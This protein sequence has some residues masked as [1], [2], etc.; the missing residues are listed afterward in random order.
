LFN[1]ALA[2]LAMSLMAS[3]V[4]PQQQECLALNV[5]HESRDQSRIGMVAVAQVVLNRVRDPRFPNTIC[6][7]VQQQ[8]FYDPPGSPIRIDNCQFSW[9]C[10]GKS[11]A[12]TEEIAWHTAQM[13]AAH[14]YYMYSIEY[15]ITEGAT[16]YHST[17]V[18]PEWSSTKVHIVD[19]DNHKFYRWE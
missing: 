4:P 12:P 8:R 11:D 17:S 9:Y 19:I 16:H 13:Q 14:A 5:Y 3:E 15:D 7:V 10:D 6:N 2:A 1:Q 18:S